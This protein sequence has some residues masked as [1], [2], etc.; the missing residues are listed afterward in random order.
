MRL[1]RLW[2]GGGGSWGGWVIVL[3][4]WWGRDRSRYKKLL[5]VGFLGSG[6]EK[7]L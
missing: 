3:G 2:C 1:V 6:R 7:R 4:L 5:R